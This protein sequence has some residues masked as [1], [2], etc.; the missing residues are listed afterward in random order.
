MGKRTWIDS[1]IWCDTEDL[2]NESRLLYLYLLTNEQRNIAGYYK[3]NLRHMAIDFGSTESRLERMLE[4]EQKYWIYD[5]ETRQV[6]IPKF[7][8]YNIVKS[9]QQ[10][11]KMN[12]ELNML[13]PCRL[14]KLF[15]E[16]FV[17]VNGIG[18]DELIDYKFKAKAQ[19]LI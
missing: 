4:R 17:E 13:K 16:A 18:A 3:V 14:H 11:T 12:A 9:K 1:D 8:R 2:D 6:L 15:I 19:E 10:Y 7:T 5:P